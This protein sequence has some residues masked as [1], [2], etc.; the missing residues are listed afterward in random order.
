MQL[1]RVWFYLAGLVL[2]LAV[3]VVAS[4][5]YAAAEEPADSYY[6]DWDTVVKKIVPVF[7]LEREGVFLGAAQVA[8]P[9]EQVEK[10]KG[11]A[12]LQLDFRGFARIRVYLPVSSISITHL[13]RVQGVSVWA[14]IEARLAEF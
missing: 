10:V 13:S 2:V 5:L 11:V 14:L 8:G 4:R 7:S 9:K 12:Q 1:R 6:P 3:V